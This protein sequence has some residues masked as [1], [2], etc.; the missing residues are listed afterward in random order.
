[1]TFQS[2]NFCAGPHHLTKLTI[3][4][5][6]SIEFLTILLIKLYHQIHCSNLCSP[7]QKL[8]CDPEERKEVLQESY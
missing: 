7:V 3:S 4:N 8:K 5:T 6:G 1:M 2:G